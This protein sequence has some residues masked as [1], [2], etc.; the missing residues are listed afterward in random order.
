[1]H[2]IKTTRNLL[3]INNVMELNMH[4]PY[5]FHS[6]QVAAKRWFERGS[7]LIVDEKETPARHVSSLAA[8]L[9]QHVDMLV[10]L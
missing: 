6:S 9:D 8:I 10:L 7:L 1:M 2:L 4:L 3:D 5:A